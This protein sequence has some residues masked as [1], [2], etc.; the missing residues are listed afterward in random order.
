MS[1]SLFIVCSLM[2][3]KY[4]NLIDMLPREKRLNHSNT[5]DSDLLLLLTLLQPYRQRFSGSLT[6]ILKHIQHLWQIFPACH[7]G[8]LLME[9][10]STIWWILPHSESIFSLLSFR[11]CYFRSTASNFSYFRADIV[12]YIFKDIYFQSMINYDLL[13]NKERSVETQSI[14]FHSNAASVSNSLKQLFLTRG[15]GPGPTGGPQYSS[16]ESA[17]WLKGIKLKQGLK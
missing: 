12:F 9:S 16:K 10:K 4:W 1:P 14:L 7:V 17:R 3:G 5:K 11:K 13:Q 6:N 8:A 15:P 2:R